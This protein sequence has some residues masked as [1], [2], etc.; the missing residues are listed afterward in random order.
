[1]NDLD[2]FGVNSCGP[3]I[4]LRWVAEVKDAPALHWTRVK[5]VNAI[6]NL[7]LC[8]CGSTVVSGPLYLLVSIVCWYLWDWWF[9]PGLHETPWGTL[10]WGWLHSKISKVTSRVQEAWPGL[11]FEHS[12][13]LVFSAHV[14]GSWSEN[15]SAFI[16]SALQKEDTWCPHL[17]SLDPWS[18]CRFWLLPAL[19]YL[20]ALAVW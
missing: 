11:H 14:D 6:T 3:R 13:S 16:R 17:V 2:G 12:D 1:M 7:L 19:L 8:H 5:T 20:S 18:W 10:L 9:A 15:E 4:G